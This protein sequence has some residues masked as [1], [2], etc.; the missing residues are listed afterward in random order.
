MQEART[1]TREAAPRKKVYHRGEEDYSEA[2]ELVSQKPFVPSYKFNFMR[3]FY[4]EDS[5]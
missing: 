1:K 4:F 3:E 2:L 5:P